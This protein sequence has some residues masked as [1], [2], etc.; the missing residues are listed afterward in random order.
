MVTITIYLLGI[1]IT[2]LLFGCLAVVSNEHIFTAGNDTTGTAAITYA[3]RLNNHRPVTYRFENYTFP[4]SCSSHPSRCRSLIYS[5]TSTSDNYT[6]LIFYVPLAEKALGVMELA[7]DNRTLSH[8]VTRAVTTGLTRRC[9]P[10]SMVDIS[11]TF[12][13]ICISDR[14]QLM[15]CEVRNSRNVSTLWLS[16][17]MPEF[18]INLSRLSNFVL[19]DARFKDLYFTHENFMCRKL[20]TSNSVQYLA[21]LPSSYSHCWHLEL[22]D[23]SEPIIA[24]YCN[25]RSDS[26]KIQSVYF[27]L[28]TQFFTEQMNATKYVRYDCPSQGTFVEVSIAGAYASY[29]QRDV[30]M[31]SFN[32]I[33]STVTFAICFEFDNATHF[34]YR[35]RHLGTFIKPNISVNLQSRVEQLLKGPCQSPA[36][37]QPL[38]FKSQFILLLNQTSLSHAQ[39]TFE[40]KDLQRGTIIP[41]FSVSDPS[42]VAL[43]SDF[44]AQLIQDPPTTSAVPSDS[45]SNSKSVTI[46]STISASGVFVFLTIAVLSP[47]LIMVYCFRSGKLPNFMR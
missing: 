37:E 28:N 42:Q 2:S 10:I 35:D 36:C 22:L 45:R 4:E 23:R 11:G 8:V 38:V 40:V 33:G 13:V 7:Y 43:K 31:G 9:S 1:V 29:M 3:S 17:P 25:L 44:V 41:N 30:Y 19:H 24:A 21:Q 32:I 47:T 34:L 6:R 18:H 14:Q 20:I 39:W 5:S 16:C 15:S 12:Y 26:N 46:T 27:N